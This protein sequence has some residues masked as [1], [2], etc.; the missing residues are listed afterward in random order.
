MTSPD[1]I[2]ISYRPLLGIENEFIDTERPQSCFRGS[3]RCDMNENVRRQIPN[4]S[5]STSTMQVPSAQLTRTAT[6]VASCKFTPL[7]IR[8]A[9]PFRLKTACPLLADSGRFVRS[10]YA[11]KQTQS[12]HHHLPN[13]SN[14]AYSACIDPASIVRRIA[15]QSPSCDCL[16]EGGLIVRYS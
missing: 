3:V 7:S 10:A 5:W 13:W 2:S 6:S 9:H 14:P 16:R 15:M 12:R 4:V 8:F 11:S 1:C